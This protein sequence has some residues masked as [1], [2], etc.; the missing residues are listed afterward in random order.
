[1]LHIKKFFKN[2][3]L[4]FFIFSFL[5]IGSAG[6]CIHS[7]SFPIPFHSARQTESLTE[8]DFEQYLNNLF[9]SELCSSTL[10]MHYSIK[11][12]NSIGITE[13]PITFGHISSADEAMQMSNYENIRNTLLKF[14]DTEMS[15][16]LRMSYDVLMD[17][18]ERNL[19]LAPYYYYHE[20]LSSTN[21]VQSEFP[22]L[23]AEYA[24]YSTKDVDEYLKLLSQMDTYFQEICEFE[25]KKAK[26]GLFMNETA[27]NN[28]INQIHAFIPEKSETSF[29]ETT[30]IERLDKIPNLSKEQRQEYI[31]QNHKILQTYVY[32]AYHNLAAVIKSLKQKGR[33]TQGLCYFEKGKTYYELLVKT[34]TGTDTPIKKLEKMVENRRNFCLHQISNLYA[35][36]STYKRNNSDIFSLLNGD[37]I[38]LSY[39]LPEDI[40]LTLQTKIKDDFP[41]LPETNFTVKTVDE[42]L[43]AFLSP[44]FYLTSPIDDYS[45]NCIYI[46]PG[47][48]YNDIELFTTLAHEG[49]PG[50]LYQTVYS[51]QSNLPPLRYLLYHGGYTEGWATYVE[52]LS[53]HYAGLSKEHAAILRLNQDAILSLYASMDMGIHYEGW[54]LGDTIEF[55]SEYGITDVITVSKI[56]ESI[57]E[58]PANYLKYYIGYL[59]FLQLKKQAEARFGTDFSV[60]SF[61]TAVLTMGSAPF[62]ILEKYLPD[63]YK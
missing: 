44:A 58:N 14:R 43:E 56:Y 60:R 40:L 55:L 18:V 48:H 1:M 10:N 16:P 29:W 52:M 12:P 22:I 32:P 3:F 27:A 4:Y 5:L 28:L 37:S 53:Y 7:Q 21:G 57:L 26:R 39:G 63:Y 62:Y 47:N 20:Y 50:H 51:Y 30:F 46:N 11:N 42:R 25:K 34:T 36:D 23:L 6:Y 38:E 19:E 24:F 15:V 33:N 13:Y 35:T 61:H 31:S 17:T 54:S 8:Q 49:Y 2:H 9:Q 59:E 45:N 41:E